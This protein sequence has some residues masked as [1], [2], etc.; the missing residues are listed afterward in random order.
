MGEPK[1]EEP[2]KEAEESQAQS[3]KETEDSNVPE[4]SDSQSQI[5]A[6]APEDDTLH[7]S[8]P[9]MLDDGRELRMRW[10][11]KDDLNEVAL[12]FAK[13]HGIP[14]EM[15][16]EVVNFA[17]QL[18]SSAKDAPVKQATHE[19]EK[20]DLNPLLQQLKDMGFA[21]LTDAVLEDLLSSN[22][23]DLN[24]VVETLMLYQ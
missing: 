18:Q 14:E 13:E 4:E 24:K 22:E 1:A 2:Q 17:K 16:P 23:N 8:F 19:N 9:I 7:F 12:A 5:R 15:V 11:S 6:C 3:K 10:Q 20:P 21:N